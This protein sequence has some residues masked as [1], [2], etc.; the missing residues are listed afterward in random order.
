M[1]M[2]E[3]QR[4]LRQAAEEA[5]KESLERLQQ[6]LLCPEDEVETQA[7]PEVELPPPIPV[8]QQPE[9]AAPAISLDELED[10]VKD[11]EQFLSHQDISQG[12][13]L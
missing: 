11:I 3:H 9:M 2:N 6:S 1:K 13:L 8:R 12:K 7:L 5:F 10:A 4:D